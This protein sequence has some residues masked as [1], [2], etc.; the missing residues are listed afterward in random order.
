MSRQ[1]DEYI[2]GCFDIHGTTYRLIEPTNINELV[3][4]LELADIIENRLNECMHHD[5]D[6]GNWEQLLQEQQDYIN[7]YADFIG[8][9]DNSLFISNL[10]YLLKKY[11]LR[12]GTLES[13][14]KVSAGYISRTTKENSPKKLSIDVVW[15]IAQFF[16]IDLDKLLF[17]EL[18]TPDKNTQLI[19]RFI[20]KLYKETQSHDIEWEIVGGSAF[21]LRKEFEQL[22]LVTLNNDEE[23]CDGAYIYH[24]DGVVADY[25][26]YLTGDIFACDSVVPGA[27]LMVVP[28]AHDMPGRMHFE[29]L[30]VSKDE[31][32]K[33]SKKLMFSTIHTSY[34]SLSEEANK[35]Y[36]L[37]LEYSYDAPLSSEMKDI[38][39]GFLNTDIK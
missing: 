39:T 23:N 28:F 8:E 20:D 16:D 35:L 11:S 7:G 6:I 25:K 31:K 14:L 22:G 38:I 37:I 4:A 10:D 18:E 5:D 1:Y 13:L 36:E 26:V 29:F 21:E 27:Q 24:A 17:E 9:Y 15:K 30:V 19:S 34:N 32:G 33:M 12:I 3:E 2:E